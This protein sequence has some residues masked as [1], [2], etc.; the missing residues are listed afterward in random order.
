M[1]TA[2]R[3]AVIAALLC[4]QAAWGQN[5]NK[6]LRVTFQAA[7]TGFDP[8][9]IHD[10]YSGHVLEAVY[11]TLLT[12]DYLARPAKL[13]ASAADMPEISA[14][15]R[16]YTFRIQKGIYFTDDPAFK[17]RKRE[18][19]ALDFAYSIRRFFDPKN[20]SPYAF[21]FTGKIVG[22]DE[23]AA[24]AKAGA[25]FDYDSPVAGLQT[26]DR[27]TLVIKL[28]QPDRDLSYVLAFPVTSAVAREVIEA[29]GDESPSHPVG[30]GPFYLKRYVRSSK[31]VLAANPGYRGKLWD[32]DPGD[33]ARFK[34]IAERMQGRSEDR[35]AGKLDGYSR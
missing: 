8:V 32:F 2:A 3:L 6:I 1:R 10:Y 35:R 15:S 23:L 30:S 16:T 19:T 13:V 22:L 27:Y 31:I 24:R 34:Q 33:N 20:R 9:R 18:L 29:Y 12:Y 11:D 14:D 5:G 17:G 7:E 25:K 4:A 21:L 26:P 28:T